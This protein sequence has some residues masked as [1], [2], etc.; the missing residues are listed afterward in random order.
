M[1]DAFKLEG[2][3]LDHI[4]D[5]PTVLETVTD[6][7]GRKVGIGWNPVDTLSPDMKKVVLNKSE[8]RN[9]RLRNF[10]KECTRISKSMTRENS[11]AKE[12]DSAAT[13]RSIVLET[14]TLLPTI[15]RKLKKAKAD[16]RSFN[17]ETNTEMDSSTPR[18]ENSSLFKTNDHLISFQ[19][20]AGNSDHLPGI[21]S[22]HIPSII[23]QTESLHGSAEPSMQLPS[24]ELSPKLKEASAAYSKVTFSDPYPLPEFDPEEIMISKIRQEFFENVLARRPEANKVFSRPFMVSMQND[25][26]K[27]YVKLP[28]YRN[29]GYKLD[30]KTDV[31]DQV[32][33]KFY[34]LEK[35]LQEKEM[36][37][38]S[39]RKDERL[40]EGRR[41]SKKIGPLRLRQ[42]K[43][44]NELSYPAAHG[45]SSFFLDSLGNPSLDE[46]QKTMRSDTQRSKG[47]QSSV[48]NS[49]R[50]DTIKEVNEEPTRNRS[51]VDPVKLDINLSNERQ[52]GKLKNNLSRL[53]QIQSMT[54]KT[55][56]QN[57]EY[58]MSYLSSYRRDQPFFKNSQLE[59]LQNMSLHSDYATARSGSRAKSEKQ[60]A[61]AFI[62]RQGMA[63]RAV[64]LDMVKEYKSVADHI[65]LN[66]RPLIENILDYH[67]LI[68]FEGGHFTLKDYENF[69]TF[70]NRHPLVNQLELAERNLLKN[71]L[72]KYSDI[73][74]FSELLTVEA[75]LLLANSSTLNDK[76]ADKRDPSVTK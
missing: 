46:T 12:E 32:Q 19:D 44:G 14:K 29:V 17:I 41:L 76:S 10:L 65:R 30:L 45:R 16:S 4:E 56:K 23:L 5:A 1:F 43:L 60:R 11:E 22:S 57:H 75:S 15:H 53:A 36:S 59:S 71:M 50:T 18:A 42:S 67:R 6:R 34:R 3:Y 37:R 54:E 20:S 24:S 47:S 39:I 38:T 70:T 66:I 61:E 9:Q 48:R 31:V 28:D 33:A 72:R 7:I 74:S 49:R 13:V 55:R 58:F 35:E 73:L 64:F 25:K 69:A 68:I 51:R 26:P 21:K 8:R 62:S 63:S 52:I 27:V 40:I 2:K